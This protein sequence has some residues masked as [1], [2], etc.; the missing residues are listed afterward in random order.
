MRAA[1]GALRPAGAMRSAPGAEM[2]RTARCGEG[3]LPR[4]MCGG[5]PKQVL[6]TGSGRVVVAGGERPPR[7]AR[8]CGDGVLWLWPARRSRPVSGL[9]SGTRCGWWRCRSLRVAGLRAGTAG[10]SSVRRGASRPWSR[11]GGCARP[12]DRCHSWCRG[13]RYAGWWAVC[14]RGWEVR[15]RLPIGG[16]SSRPS[17]ARRSRSCRRGRSRWRRIDR[18]GSCRASPWLRCSA[19]G[20]PLARSSRSAPRSAMGRVPSKGRFV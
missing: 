4:Q 20:S 13:S 6:D 15:Q 5:E 11:G 18:P 3:G 17:I 14:S 10:S 8:L 2:H 16:S 1:A 12:G 9:R 19:R 7:P